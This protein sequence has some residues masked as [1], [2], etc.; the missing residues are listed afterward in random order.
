MSWLLGLRSWVG[1]ESRA[2][3][4]AP[5]DVGDL[6]WSVNAPAVLGTLRA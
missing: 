2:V 1:E 3:A 5:A 4:L 6:R